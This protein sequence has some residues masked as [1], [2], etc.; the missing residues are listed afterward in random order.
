MSE[1][2]IPRYTKQGFWIGLPVVLFFA[3]ISWTGFWYAADQ[4]ITER[5]VYQSGKQIIGTV[6]KKILFH[7]TKNGE[8]VHY[9]AYKFRTPANVTVSNKIR[10]EFVVWNSL[11]EN[12]PIAIRY[13][14]NR[15]ELNL[16]DGWH[17][18]TF[19]YWA[20]GVALAGGLLFSTIFFGM[21][22]KK[23]FGGYH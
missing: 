18:Q 20:G 9:I 19:Y 10:I 17:M 1:K 2:A 6:V 16:P 5:M 11:R 21:L 8:Q 13:V 15:P 7:Q 3:G 14:P 4:I 12:G 22:I 23:H